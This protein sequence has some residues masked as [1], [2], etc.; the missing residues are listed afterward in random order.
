M[1]ASHRSREGRPLALTSPGDENWPSESP[2]AAGRVEKQVARCLQYRSGICCLSGPG[3]KMEIPA[4]MDA[5]TLS[6]TPMPISEFQMI[7]SR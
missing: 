7:F 5:C 3:L 1:A 2:A 6:G 4:K